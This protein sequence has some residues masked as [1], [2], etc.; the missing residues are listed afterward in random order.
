MV[1]QSSSAQG[2][3]TRQDVAQAAGVSLTTVTHAL[4][5]VPGARVA[6]ATR[7]RIQ[8]LAREMGYRPNFVGR[9]LVE[10]KTYTI[11]LLQPSYDSVYN[12]FYQT[13]TR[14][15]AQAMEPDD[16]HL[17]ALFRSDDHRYLK[18]ITQGRVDGLFILQSDFSTAHIARVLETGLPTVVVNK[19]YDVAAFPHAGCVCADH[20]RMMREAVDELAARGCRTVLLVDDFRACDANARMTEGFDAAVARQGA[21]GMAGTTLVPD[22]QDF[23]RQMRNLFAAGSRWDGIIVDGVWLA[24]I[25]LAE[26]SRAGLCPGRDF[27]LISSDVVDGATTRQRQELSAYTQQPAVAGAE[28]WRVMRQLMEGE[29][30]A[31]MVLVPYRRQP[32]AGAPAF[33]GK[34]HAE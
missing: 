13:M 28:A 4:N 27:L 31:R 6:E 14:G 22:R 19:Q 26:A 9:A 11:G 20:G 18:V 5:P 16:Y 30:G 2:R 12:S 24:E 7:A 17:L 32:V 15:M 21:A 25:V 23:A 8:R 3:V 10:G 33:P 1:K 29:A 34:E